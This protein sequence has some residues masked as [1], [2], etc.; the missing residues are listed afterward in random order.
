VKKI[1][2]FK[3]LF[4]S[5]ESFK[6]LQYILNVYTMKDIY[7]ATILCDSCNGRTQKSPVVKDGFALR[8][9]Y[10]SRCE[11]HWYHPLDLQNY[12]EFIELR[13]R[14]FQVKLREVGNSWIVSIPKEII[15]F[16]EISATKIVNM[17]LDEPG[18]IT[19]RFTRV[20]K[21]Y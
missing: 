8:S 5:G 2:C 4:Y 1:A 12:K 15:R 3:Y 21:L 7:D 18:R 19:L 10:C 6:Y 17:S 20:R 11:K 16:E 13:K 9:W 14:D